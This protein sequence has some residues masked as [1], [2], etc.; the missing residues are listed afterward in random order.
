MVTDGFAVKLSGASVTLDPTAFEAA[1]ARACRAFV[2]VSVVTASL[3]SCV[4]VVLQ[5][6]KRVAI[7]KASQATCFGEKITFYQRV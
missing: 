3:A 6:D 2:D 4:W 7:V 1:K 5:A